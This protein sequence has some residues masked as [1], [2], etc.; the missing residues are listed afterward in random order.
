[1]SLSGGQ[2]CKVRRTNCSSSMPIWVTGSAGRR[3]SV[4]AGRCLNVDELNNVFAATSSFHTC[5]GVDEDNSAW[6]QAYEFV[7]EG[8]L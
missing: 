5:A 4:H 1:M 3:L 7:K 6:F 2:I 8:F